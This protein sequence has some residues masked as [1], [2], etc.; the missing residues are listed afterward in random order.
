MKKVIFSVLLIL[1]LILAVVIVGIGNNRAKEK[2][3][4]S[5]NSQFENYNRKNLYGADIL[6][7]INKAIDNNTIYEIQKDSNGFY[8]E[9]NEK[10]VKVELILLSTND[11]GEIEERTYQMESLEKAGLTGFISNFGLTP[12]ECTSI[13]YNKKHRVSKI[14]VKQ[15][16]I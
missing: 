11:K 3:I 14:T 10:S 12:F 2:E 15:L 9:D 7:I 16:E 13:E 6:T 4:V 8:I 1:I 5:F